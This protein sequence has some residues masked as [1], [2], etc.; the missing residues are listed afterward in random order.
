MEVIIERDTTAQVFR[1]LREGLASGIVELLEI[2]EAS[3]KA[4]AP[5]LT[6]ALREGIHTDASRVAESLFGTVESAPDLE[7][8]IY[9]E[10]GTYKMAAQPHMLPAGNDV[11]AAADGVMANAIN[12]RLSE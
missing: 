3:A 5:V 6:G 11:L 7:Y 10:L 9:Q 12:R 1:D 8:P 2:G 4:H